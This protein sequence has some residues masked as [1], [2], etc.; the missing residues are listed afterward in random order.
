VVFVA[1][2]KIWIA[3]EEEWKIE[4][5]DVELMYIELMYIELM[6]IEDSLCYLKAVTMVTWREWEVRG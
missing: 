3:N 4:M 6:Y 5:A 2:I 1:C